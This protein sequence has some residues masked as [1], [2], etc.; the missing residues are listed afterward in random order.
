MA[1]RSQD[2]SR[3]GAAVLP[4]STRLVVVAGGPDPD[5]RRSAAGCPGRREVARG[6]GDGAR[7]RRIRRGAAGGCDRR[8]RAVP[9]GG[10]AAGRLVA[11]QGG[12]GRRGGGADVRH[13]PGRELR[14]RAHHA[15][16]QHPRCSVLRESEVR[17]HARA[18][19]ARRPDELAE[20]HVGVLLPVARDD[21]AGCHPGD[22]VDHAL[23]DSPGDGRLGV[24]ATD[25]DQPLLQTGLGPGKQLGAPLPA[26][27][28]SHRTDERAAG[29]ERG[30]AVRAIRLFRSPV[31]GNK[32]ATAAAR[33]VLLRARARYGVQP[34][35]SSRTR[36]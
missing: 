2:D 10:L 24:A 13:Q 17:R 35:A 33:A 34:W 23:G 4:G 18:G 20:L 15:Q 36:R 9:A 14:S 28:I 5:P 8:A 12:V 25:R 16:V 3:G 6:R 22:P 30:A 26:A 11:G 19:A 27:E 32:R 7:H 31:P 29:R 1:K 21:V